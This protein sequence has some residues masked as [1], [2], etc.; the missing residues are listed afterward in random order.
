MNSPVLQ[1]G[2]WGWGGVVQDKDCCHTRNDTNCLSTLAQG[3]P[4]PLPSAHKQCSAT[5]ITKQIL[6][7]QV[8]TM[9]PS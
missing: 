4:N 2:G 1:G 7:I 5:I 9:I 3:S 6:H 8:S